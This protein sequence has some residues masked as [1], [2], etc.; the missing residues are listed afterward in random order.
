VAEGGRH[1]GVLTGATTD[2]EHPADQAPSRG[3]VVESWLG[4]PDVPRW[5]A[6]RV[7]GLEVGGR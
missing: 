3:Q 2:I 5:G 4:S 7:D 1:K 6:D